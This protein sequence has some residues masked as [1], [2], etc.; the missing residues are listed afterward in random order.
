MEDLLEKQKSLSF[1]IDEMML[2]EMQL[3]KETS[4]LEKSLAILKH[5]L[6]EVKHAGERKWNPSDP[7]E[8]FLIR[9]ITLG[10]FC[11]HGAVES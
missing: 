5:D 9:R 4:N 3:T 11:L 1:Q 7:T 6:K 10:S 2:R 8:C